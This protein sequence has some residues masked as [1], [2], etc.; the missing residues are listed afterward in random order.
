MAGIVYTYTHAVMAAASCS[1]LCCDHCMMLPKVTYALAWL[2]LA[3]H[4]V[5]AALYI[6]KR[7]GITNVRSEAQQ[8][9]KRGKQLDHS[10]PP[11][12]FVA[13]TDFLMGWQISLRARAQRTAHGALHG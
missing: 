5:H 13:H 9:H 10:R 6:R 12:L 2:R 11:H 3:A 4:C 7:S 1:I 8:A